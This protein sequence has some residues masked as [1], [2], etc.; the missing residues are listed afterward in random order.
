MIKLERLPEYTDSILHG[1]T[2]D[3]ELKHRIL[4]KA[5]EQPEKKNHF[6]FRTV[7]VLCSVIAVLLFAVLLLNELKPVPVSDQGEMTVF[8]AGSNHTASPEM[9]LD[10]EKIM[11]ETDSRTISRIEFVDGTMISRPETGAVLF[12]ILK[13]KAIPVDNRD[14]QES[15]VMTIA[16]SDG[17]SIQL[18]S[19]PPLLTDGKKVWTCQE[20]FD[21]INQLPAGN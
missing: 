21:A 16:F 2:A 10:F 17:S 13:D 20:F 6:L 1:L 7:P 4:K 11:K 5:S 14:L 19:Y 8:A 3:Q 18:E 12:S 9:V 15:D